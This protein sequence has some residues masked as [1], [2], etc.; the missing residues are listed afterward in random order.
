MVPATDWNQI[1]AVAGV[2]SFIAVLGTAVVK[3]VQNWLGEKRH[4]HNR[5]DLLEIRLFGLPAD[6]Q[7]GAKKLDGEFDRIDRRFD[8]LPQIIASAV[9]ETKQ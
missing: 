7:T 1:G 9:R 4:E 3:V 8:E 5:V 2:L 6:L